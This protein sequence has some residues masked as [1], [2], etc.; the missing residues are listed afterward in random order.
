MD[1]NNTRVMR[2]EYNGATRAK[3][4]ILLDHDI[5]ISVLLG[6]TLLSVERDKCSVYMIF[7]CSDGTRYIM[8]HEQDCCEYVYI[9]DISGCMDDILGVPVLL[10]EVST[11]ASNA[12][13]DSTCTWTYYK[14]A[15]IK[16]DLSIRWYGSSNGYYSEEVGFEQ[17]A[18]DQ[19]SEV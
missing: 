10:A 15:T 3:F 4:N 12:S 17:L 6:K 13:A 9:E 19:Q 1:S 7:S 2:I 11:S 5:S 16:G 18:P 14:L 8:A